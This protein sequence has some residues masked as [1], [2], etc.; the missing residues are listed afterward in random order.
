[1]NEDQGNKHLKALHNRREYIASLESKKRDSA[2][3]EH[4]RLATG[5]V[6]DTDLGARLAEQEVALILTKMEGVEMI[7]IDV[8]IKKVHDGNYGICESCGEP[9]AVK[10]LEI[11]PEASY[12]TSCEPIGK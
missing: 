12:C 4:G 3:L 9:I 7:K 5:D 11:L 2:L 8:A 1:M 10:R 6:G